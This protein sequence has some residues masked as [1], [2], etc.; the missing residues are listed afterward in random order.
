MSYVTITYLII[1]YWYLKKAEIRDMKTREC[2]Y[3]PP[4]GSKLTEDAP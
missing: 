4:A 1:C 2:L 3:T